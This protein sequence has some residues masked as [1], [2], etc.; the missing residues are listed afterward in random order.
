MNI[1]S[2]TCFINP[3]WPLNAELFSQMGRFI[4]TARRAYTE[5]GFTVQTVRLATVP[6]PT[7]APQAS[8]VKFATELSRAAQSEGFDYVA[9]GPALP[10]QPSSYAA[11]SEILA[12]VQG[13]F[14][15]GLLTLPDRPEVSLPAVQACAHIIH[16][17]ATLSPDGFGNLHFAAL[18]N[19]PAGS[20]FYPAAYHRPG[21]GP[22]FAM[23]LEAADLAVTAFTGA[24]TITGARQR[25]Q[26]SIESQAS[27]LEA[28]G[29]SLADAWPVTFLGLDFT[30]APFPEGNRSLGAALERLGVPAVGLSGS[31]AA[32][33]ILAEGLDRARFKR[34]GFNGLMLPVLEDATLAVRAAQ[35]LLRVNDLLLYSAV[36][37]TG[38]D[39]LP[40]PGDATPEQLAAILLDLAALALRLDKPLTARLM[41]VPGKSAGDLT[42]FDFDYF[43]NSRILALAAEPLTGPMAGNEVFELRSRH[44]FK[45]I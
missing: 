29:K 16:Q 2:I 42:G 5:A 13:A 38:L 37:G 10:D 4:Q 35:G 43:A 31:L 28:T 30:L 22:A 33:A 41:P 12:A 40:L 15:T 17:A 18:A 8:W 3:G 34:T 9:L 19:V 32:A 20:P 21:E 7:L 6:F 1:R 11:V 44:S 14:V 23:A 24:S 26:E 25:L 36:C 39:T 27:R 45:S